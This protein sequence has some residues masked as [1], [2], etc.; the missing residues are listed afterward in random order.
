MR[1]P[2]ETR[3]KSLLGT[4]GGDRFSPKDR[5][6]SKAKSAQRGGT[7]QWPN[8]ARRC[9]RARLN[10]KSRVRWI[11]YTKKKLKDDHGYEMP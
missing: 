3:S 2:Q 9:S 6:N 8:T 10:G 5:K 7:V 11:R 4:Q 1:P